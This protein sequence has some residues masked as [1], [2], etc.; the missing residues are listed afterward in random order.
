MWYL[1]DFH[2]QQNNASA[3]DFTTQFCGYGL[4]GETGPLANILYRRRELLV[5][6][7]INSKSLTNFKM[8]AMLVDGSP[9]ASREVDEHGLTFLHVGGHLSRLQHETCF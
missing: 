3:C 7:H 6:I 9:P 8:I 2:E 1:A 5:I 4:C